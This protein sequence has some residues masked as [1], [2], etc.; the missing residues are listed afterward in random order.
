ML[1]TM[2]VFFISCEHDGC[3]REDIGTTI[4]PGDENT[5]FYSGDF[6]D[7]WK[8]A[9]VDLGLPSGT[10]WATRNLGEYS[11]H[12]GIGNYYAWGDPSSR[13][14]F[15]WET[16]KWGRPTPEGG[17]TKYCSED[18]RTVLEPS[19][20]PATVEMGKGWSTP[21]IEQWKELIENTKQTWR[22][23]GPAY[24][25]GELQMMRTGVLFKAKNGNKMFLP[26][27]G[28]YVG[29]ANTF[30]DTNGLGYFG[31]IGEYWCNSLRCEDSY[32]SSG[33]VFY[34]EKDFGCSFNAVARSG[35]LQVRAVHTPIK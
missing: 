29:E 26:A 19:D 2:A 33:N 32:M 5:E 1:M 25:F 13:S 20:D 6:G 24:C 17:I 14:A 9:Y 16:Y 4:H 7:H 15:T 8:N 31:I 3:Y 22:D 27:A 21:T 10:L 11:Y 28:S 34:F 18:N 35:G 23:G 12:A 30:E